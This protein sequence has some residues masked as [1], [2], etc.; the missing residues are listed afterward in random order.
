M[1]DRKPLVTF[2]QGDKA[3]KDTFADVVHEL[4]K[5]DT[6]YRYSPSLAKEYYKY[7]PANYR[8]LRDKK[9][10]ERFVITDQESAAKMNKKLGKGVRTIPKGMELFDTKINQWIFGNKVVFVDYNSKS[11][12]T[13]ENKKIA[14]FQKAIFKL[15]YEKLG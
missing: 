7:L 11:I 15:L 10:L 14:Q 12:I 3:I 6:Y 8:H 4:K 5:G 9:Q 13:V 2:A 1:K